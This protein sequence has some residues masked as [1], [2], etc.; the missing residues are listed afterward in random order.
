[1]SVATVTQHLAAFGFDNPHGVIDSRL[2]LCA[3]LCFHAP[4]AFREC[5]AH[6]QKDTGKAP[7]VFS[8]SNQPARPFRRVQPRDVQRT[9]QQCIPLR[10]TEHSQ[11]VV[12]Q[13]APKLTV[14]TAQAGNLQAQPVNLCKC[15]IQRR[16]HVTVGI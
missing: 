1:M 12:S 16:C 10:T 7:A 13:F 5:T 6:P 15:R 8:Y 2:K 11:F 9:D 4:R 3:G 14:L